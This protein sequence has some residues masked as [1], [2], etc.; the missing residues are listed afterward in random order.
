MSVIE[1]IFSDQFA[2]I[3]MAAFIGFILGG[4]YEGGRKR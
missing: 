2:Y 1:Y 3:F 4:I